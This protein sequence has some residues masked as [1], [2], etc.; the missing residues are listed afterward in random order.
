MLKEVSVARGL[1][2]VPSVLGDARQEV[3]NEAL[4]GKKKAYFRSSKAY[5]LLL[6]VPGVRAS[7]EPVH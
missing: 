1:G 3:R 5:D 7:Q 6:C 4:G 2:A